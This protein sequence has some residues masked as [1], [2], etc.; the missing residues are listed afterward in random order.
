MDGLLGMRVRDEVGHDGCI[1]E[2]G[3]RSLRIDWTDTGVLTPKEERL[4][5]ESQETRKLQVLTLTEG[6]KPMSDLIRES[7]AAPKSLL[8]DLEGLL[9]ESSESIAEPITEATKKVSGKSL[10]KKAREKRRSRGKEG[11]K[12]RGGHNPFKT[13]TKL[14]PGPRHGTNSQTHKWKCSCPTPYK[15]MCRAGKKRK[16]IKIKRSYKKN[17]NVDY[18]QWRKHQKH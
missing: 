10:E 16:T 14:G 17:Y 15:C 8:E 18:K 1:V 11:K 9:A 3:Q 2:A 7:S 5:L 12:G 13:K 4:W 6:W